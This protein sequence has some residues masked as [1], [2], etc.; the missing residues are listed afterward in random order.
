M[1]RNFTTTL[2]AAFLVSSVLAGGAL[3]QDLKPFTFSLNVPASGGQ[4]GFIYA[5]ELGLYEAEGL[6]VTIQEGAGSATTAQIVATGQVD[7]AMA[8]APT[9]MQFRAQGAPLT[10]IAPILQTNAYG[11]ITLE[12]SGIRTAADLEGKRVGM[13]PGTAMAALFDGIVE[14]QELDASQIEVVNVSI[15]ALVGSLLEQQVDAI[16]AGADFQGIQVEDRAPA[17]IIMFADVGIP[18]IGL[19]VF[20]RDD[21]LERDPEAVTA[22]LR[23]GFEGWRMALEDPEAAAAAV[24]AQFPSANAGEVL[25][26]LRVDLTLLCNEDSETLAKVSPEVWQANYDMLIAY[27]GVSDSVPIG[28][29]YSEDYLPSDLPA[30]S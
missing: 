23:A 6:D 30:C 4:V 26:Q 2:S 22:F 11:I 14:N 18:S 9:I 8:D 15:P 10:I 21:T 24:Q 1:K 17:H 12:Q 16:L 3:A 19:S 28:D 13:D 7:L 29:Y 25:K 27:L 5:K 20:G